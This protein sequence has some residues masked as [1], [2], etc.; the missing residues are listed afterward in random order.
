M[1]LEEC[2]ILSLR[3]H[4]NAI[5]PFLKNSTLADKDVI[6]ISQCGSEAYLC[7][8]WGFIDVDTR[9]AVVR[10]TYRLNT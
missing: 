4:K 1:W 9:D 2:S 8:N 5:L 10:E 6:A 7:T 3:I